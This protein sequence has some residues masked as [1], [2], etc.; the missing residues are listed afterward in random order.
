[1]SQQR[2]FRFKHDEGHTPYPRLMPRVTNAHRERQRERILRA[3]ARCFARKGFHA[4]SM[5]ELITEAG[6]SSSTV[7]RY[8]PQ[9]KQSIIEAVSD[10]RM[11]PVIARIKALAEM[12]D[13]PGPEEA[14]I[15][16]LESLWAQERPSPAQLGRE[17]DDDVAW[18]FIAVAIWGDLARDPELLAR[19]NQRYHDMR[20]I[21][22]RLCRRWQSLGLLTEEITAEQIA[23]LV[24]STSFGL[25]IEFVSTGSSD[26]VS[27]AAA[28]SRMLA[29][30]TGDGA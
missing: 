24:Q 29:P 14:F 1:M 16:T 10:R 6:M 20:E 30:R 3:A 12:D 15:D 28:L 22:T 17:E 21:L 9:G 13:P 19:S 7:Y 4:T 18:P 11:M 5:D 2:S 25:M 23:A 8:F 27:A 26:V